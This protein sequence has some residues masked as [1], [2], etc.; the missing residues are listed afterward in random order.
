V[1]RTSCVKTFALTTSKMG[2]SGTITVNEETIDVYIAREAYIYLYSKSAPEEKLNISFWSEREWTAFCLVQIGYRDGTFK[3]YYIEKYEDRKGHTRSVRDHVIDDMTNVSVV[4]VSI[5]DGHHE[6]IDFKQIFVEEL[7]NEFLNSLNKKYFFTTQDIRTPPELED[8]KAEFDKV[9]A[10]LTDETFSLT[11]QPP[12]SLECTNFNREMYKMPVLCRVFCEYDIEMMETFF[13][14]KQISPKMESRPG[15]EKV[16]TF[17][18]YGNILNFKDYYYHV[19]DGST[20][21]KIFK[22]KMHVADIEFCYD[23]LPAIKNQNVKYFFKLHIHNS[24]MVEFNG[25]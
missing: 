5:I 21:I 19:N 22:E 4:V 9:L 23:P 1:Y 16:F 12:P 8:A 7:K 10:E 20:N 14:E 25:P 13:L 2:M 18:E 6:P 11:T 17:D 3:K 15:I 24:T